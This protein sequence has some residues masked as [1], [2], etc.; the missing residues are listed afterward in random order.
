MARMFW[1][2][3]SA[4]GKRFLAPNGGVRDVVGVVADTRHRGLGREPRATLFESAR[5]LGTS[6]LSFVLRTRGAPGDLAPVARAAL[7][8]VDRAPLIERVS[9]MDD[10]VADSMKT[11]RY[12]ALLLQFFALAALVVTAIG[13]ALAVP[14]LE[15]PDARIIACAWRSARPRAG[16][17]AR[18]AAIAGFLAA[19]ACLGAGGAL[20]A[21]RWASTYFF[22]VMVRPGDLRRGGRR[23]A[24]RLGDRGLAGVAA[25]GPRQ[26]LRGARRAV[27]AR[28]ARLA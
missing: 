20:G 2:G 19:G 25:A 5:Q 26:P 12:R 14:C 1:P 9:T 18:A 15:R 8:G 22:G 17:A 24:D 23:V 28:A 13:L 3:E 11:E 4:I 16:Q 21:M 10:L 27:S 6:R 7:V